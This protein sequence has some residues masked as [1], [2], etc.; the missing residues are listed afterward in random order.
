M[1]VHKRNQDQRTIDMDYIGIEE[2]HSRKHAY[3][4]KLSESLN[5]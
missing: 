4:Q 2:S 5:M 1:K 3:M